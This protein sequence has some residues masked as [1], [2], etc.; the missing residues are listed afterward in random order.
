VEGALAS[1]RAFDQQGVLAFEAGRY[2]D[3][4]L[5]FQAALAHGGPSSERWNA[6]KCYLRLDQPEEAESE[7]VA[8]LALP[9]LGPDD[10]REGA[11]ALD[12]LRRQ[13]STL[14]VIS[15]PLRLAVRLDGRH[16]G[17][18]PLSIQVPPGEHVVVVD[19]D[20]STHDARRIN[21][22]LGRAIIVEA[23]P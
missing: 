16:V 2:H 9:G 6:A 17:A 23:T 3:A 21:A 12:G 8:Y 18:T 11:A 4:L 19:R 14:T 20:A 10:A 7:L 22:H 5:Y 1:A 13:S 15:T